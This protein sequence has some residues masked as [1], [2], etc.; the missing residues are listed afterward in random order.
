MV[1]TELEYHRKQAIRAAE[2]LY[3]D[4]SVIRK[5]K[6]AKTEREMDCIMS[7]ARKNK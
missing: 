1:Y 4:K 7:N 5:L 3:Y 6:E 2:E